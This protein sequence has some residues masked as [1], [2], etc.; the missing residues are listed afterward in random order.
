[1]R[2]GLIAHLMSIFC[3]VV[4]GTTFL[5]TKVLLKSFDPV[6]ILVM[7]LVICIFL[8][9]IL[10]PKIFMVEKRIHEL[11]F[12]GAGASGICYYFLFENFALKY[13][14]A[15][16]VG[17]IV[18]MAPMFTMIFCTIAFRNQKIKWNFIVGFV[19]AILGIILISF[20]GNKSF[21][22]NP[23]GDI[24]ALI[25]MVMWGI[26]SVFVQK[27]SMLGY[28]GIG[29]TRKIMYY[30]LL[31]LIP[32][33][34][35]MKCDFNYRALSNYKNILNL[36]FLGVFASTM[37]FV[38]WNYAVR[39]IGSMKTTIYLYI[40]PAITLIASVIIIHEDINYI[41]VIGM[42]MSVIGLVFSGDLWKKKKS[43]SV[44]EKKQKCYSSKEGDDLSA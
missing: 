13:T 2:R 5:S 4:W 19:I 23:K 26:Y 25:A 30:G 27:I 42:L 22:L 18:S 32:F 34:F 40:S 14:S 16:N 10:Y 15:S 21:G 7:R 17:V 29:T 28:G 3:I 9:I 20:N 36:L 33:I 37:C 39:T 38:F 35:I 44:E 41:S 24:L 43:T 1:M 11:L 8:L 6:M 31:F 12:A